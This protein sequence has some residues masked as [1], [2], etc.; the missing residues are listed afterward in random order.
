MASL[1]S[2]KFLGKKLRSLRKARG[3][4]QNEL[5]RR[6]G[7]HVTSISDWERGDNEPSGRHV[8]SL[9]RELKVNVDELYGSDDDEEDQ[10]RRLRQIRAELVLAG[11]DDIAE[12]LRLL[13]IVSSI[14]GGQS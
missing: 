10:V 7:A 3:W 4:S 9:A 13:A 14:D 12:D 11:R 8:V 2:G 5:G 1:L 6:I